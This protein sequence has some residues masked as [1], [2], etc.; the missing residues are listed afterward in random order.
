LRTWF[1]EGIKVA[2]SSDGP[3]TPFNPW[4]GMWAAMTRRTEVSGEVLGD[5]ERITR[6]EALRMYTMN[7]AL[8][9]FD[10]GVKG[11]IE[12]GKYADMLVVD[13]DLIKCSDDEFKDTKVLTTYLSGKKVYE[14]S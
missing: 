9:T 2:G 7:G 4:M 13:T 12:A 6:F 1:N 10:E 11:S 5:G 14:A 8:A 3:V